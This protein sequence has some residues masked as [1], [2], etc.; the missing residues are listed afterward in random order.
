MPTLSYL[1]VLLVFVCPPVAGLGLVAV[2][3]LTLPHVVVVTCL[4]VLGVTPTDG[5]SA[6]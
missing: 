2:A 3:V 4:D 5:T 1:A 6:L